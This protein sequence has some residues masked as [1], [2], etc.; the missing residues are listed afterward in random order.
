MATPQQPLT[1]EQLDKFREACIA[2][3]VRPSPFLASLGKPRRSDVIV[4][5]FPWRVRLRRFWDRLL[6]RIGWRD[7][8]PVTIRYSEIVTT[9]TLKPKS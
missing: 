1:K 6:K 2:D 7:P 3:Y 4:F 8:D 9:I 5:R